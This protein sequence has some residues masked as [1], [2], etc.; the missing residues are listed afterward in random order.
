MARL[1]QGMALLILTFSTLRQRKA[2]SLTILL[3]MALLACVLIST[4]SITAGITR[5]YS[6]GTAAD[7]AIVL[8]GLSRFEASS[9]IDRADAGIILDAPGIAR[10]ASGRLLADEELSFY[11]QPTHH[12]F[13]GGALHIRGMKAAGLA[14]RS[15]R[16]ISGR[17]FQSGRQELMIGTGAAHGFNLKVGDT[18]IMRDGTW[19][20]VG[21]FEAQGVMSDE[22]FADADT[23]ATLMHQSGFGSVHVK[24]AQPARFAEFR[25]WLTHNPALHLSAETQLQYNARLAAD[26]AQYFTAMAYFAGFI[27]SLGALF[28][29]VNVLHGVVSART[30]EMA[31][32][33]GIGYDAIPVAA[34]VLFEALALCV[35]GALLGGGLAWLLF[36]G[37]EVMK[38]DVVFKCVVT[39]ETLWLAVGWALVLAVGGSLLPMRRAGRLE[40]IAA[41]RVV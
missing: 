29:S 26:Q 8:P 13:S 22:L 9:G 24:L 1:R 40:V 35:A 23:L 18:V 5:E 10:D 32:L 16:T 25:D 34:S 31:I 11:V 12:V 19:P 7:L 30:R 3:C 38:N 39:P 14:M 17:A 41:L 15:F 21:V 2:T 4:L 20:I 6:A 37:H 33:R 36:D 28:G 27:M